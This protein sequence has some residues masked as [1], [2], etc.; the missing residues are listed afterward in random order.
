MYTRMLLPGQLRI[1]VSV[2]QLRAPQTVKNAQLHYNINSVAKH[3]AKTVQTSTCGLL[4]NHV[5]SFEIQ[6]E[7]NEEGE[8][9]MQNLRFR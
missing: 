6:E 5:L 4:L 9:K 2:N 7:Q 3:R 8:K 1:Q